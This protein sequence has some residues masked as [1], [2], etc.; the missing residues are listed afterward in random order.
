MTRLL[1]VIPMLTLGLVACAAPIED[2]APSDDLG[3]QSQ[4]LFFSRLP[5]YVAI[6]DSVDYGVGASPGNGY[7]DQFNAWLEDNYFKGP[8]DFLNLAV[9]GAT[10]QQ[11]LDEQTDDAVLFNVKHVFKKRVMSVGS[12]GNDL[13]GF[14]Q[15]PAFLPCATGDQATCQANLGA[16]LAEYA[17]NLD[18]TMKRLRFLASEH[19]AVLVA[20]TQ[21]TGFV[22]PNC[23]TI[24]GIDKDGNLWLPAEQ[25]RAILPLV[26]LALE[27]AVQDPSV[28][29]DPFP[30]LNDI[31]RQKA[32]KY[33]AVM[34]DTMLPILGAIQSGTEVISRDC[35]HPNDAGHD[36]ITNLVIDA[37]NAQN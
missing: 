4:A 18:T 33:G 30:G 32:E 31:M 6:G 35:V 11:I 24:G 19:R 29:N 36:L 16:V 2:S 26:F 10:S 3:N 9:P 13:L 7:T 15:S 37:F 27:G 22:Q 34:V 21:Y 1:T 25:V 17:D 5:G 14:M 23:T 20:R 28:T 12:G 8:S